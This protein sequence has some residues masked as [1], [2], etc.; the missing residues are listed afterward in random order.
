MQPHAFTTATILFDDYCIPTLDGSSW[1]RPTPEEIKWSLIRGGPA[2]DLSKSAQRLANELKATALL[3]PRTAVDAI[4]AFNNPLLLALSTAT[5]GDPNRPNALFHDKDFLYPYWGKRP[6]QNYDRSYQET[7]PS[8]GKGFEDECWLMDAFLSDRRSF[9]TVVRGPLEQYI[10]GCLTQLEARS[11]QLES[12]PAERSMSNLGALVSQSWAVAS[13]IG[14]TAEDSGH[15]HRSLN[16]IAE[17]YVRDG[18]RFRIKTTFTKIEKLAPPHLVSRLKWA[19]YDYVYLRA[20]SDA[21]QA[22]ATGY[23]LGTM[24]SDPTIGTDLDAILSAA[25]RFDP[26]LI[27]SLASHLG[28]LS[29]DVIF[30]EIRG[31]AYFRAYESELAQAAAI[32]SLEDRSRALTTAVLKYFGAIAPILYKLTGDD[33]F[34][35]VKWN[36]TDWLSLGGSAFLLLLEYTLAVPILGFIDVAQRAPFVDAVAKPL[37]DALHVRLGRQSMSRLLP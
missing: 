31:S 30:S 17:D 13:Q 26:T 22:G 12:D 16:A 36:H 20:H 9:D 19:V 14:L 25:P 33:A 6:T 35:G 37:R 29:F 3:I 18:E 34:R 2:N 4:W 7:Y 15:F 1:R 27:S 10:S 28:S 5:P 8:H 24:R 11:F 23:S 32:T 21:V